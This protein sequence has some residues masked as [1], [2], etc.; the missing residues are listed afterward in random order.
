MSNKKR[1]GWEGRTEEEIRALF[2][3]IFYA[4]YYDFLSRQD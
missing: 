4:A 2:N 3:K 1:T